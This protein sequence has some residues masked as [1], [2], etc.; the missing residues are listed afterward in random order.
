MWLFLWDRI[1]SFS[2]KRKVP[3]TLEAVPRNCRTSF[4][5]LGLAEFR[6][7]ST[8]CL[9]GKTPSFVT[10]CPRMITSSWKRL[11]FSGFNFKPASLILWITWPSLDICSSNYLLKMSMSSK[12]IR[13]ISHWRPFSAISISLWK[14]PGALVRPTGIFCTQSGHIL[15]WGFLGFKFKVE[16]MVAPATESKQSW[17]LGRGKASLNVKLLILR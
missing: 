15:F 10:L 3:E 12:Y 13:Q 2:L 11:Q 5:L 9:P 17:I 6:I 14:V 16:N 1:I 4:T 8:F 7:L